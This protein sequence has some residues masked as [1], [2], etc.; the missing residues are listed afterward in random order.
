MWKTE[1]LIQSRR[2]SLASE[3]THYPVLVTV[4]ESRAICY[5]AKSTHFIELA[6]CTVM[7]FSLENISASVAVTVTDSVAY[8]TASDILIL[9][10]DARLGSVC[11]VPTVI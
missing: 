1:L 9:L 11:T 2:E 8:T 10:G 4:S 3:T 5:T 7:S 6:F